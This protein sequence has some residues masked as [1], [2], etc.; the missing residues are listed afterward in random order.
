MTKK[1]FRVC[2]LI[3]TMTVGALIGWSVA[4]GNAIIPIPAAMRL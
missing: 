4:I 1:W 2:G 3:I